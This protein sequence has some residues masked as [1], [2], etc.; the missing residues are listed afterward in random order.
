[1]DDLEI[2]R[3]AAIK[4]LVGAVLL[5]LSTFVATWSVV[6]RFVGE[7]AERETVVTTIHKLVRGE[8]LQEVRPPQRDD[9][10]K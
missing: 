7:R 1:M 5:G 10:A 2:R 8:L 6:R 3:E 9:S 4:R